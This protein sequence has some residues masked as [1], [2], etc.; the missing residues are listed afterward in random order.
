MKIHHTRG[1]YPNGSFKDN[2]VRSEDLEA[3][4]EYNKNWRFGRA[5]FVDGV[6][7]YNGFVAEEILNKHVGVVRKYQTDTIPYH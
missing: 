4:I 2:G 1:V 5:L 6:L 7:V 3:H